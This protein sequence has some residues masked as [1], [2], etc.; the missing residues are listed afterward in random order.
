MARITVEDCL[1]KI[2]NMF[3]L[4]LV[5][6]KRA[7][8]LAN[9]AHP[10]VDWENDKPT[11]VALREIA[12]GYIT[13]EI[14]TQRDKP[15]EDILAADLAAVTPMSADDLLGS[16]PVSIGDCR[17]EPD[18]GPAT[19]PV[20]QPPWTM[21]PPRSIESSSSVWRTD[22]FGRLMGQLERYL[23]SRRSAEHQRGLRV[24]RQGSPR[25]AAAQRRSVHL[26][27]RRR[28]GNPRQPPSRRRVDQGG[29]AAR[30][31]RGHGKHAAGDPRALRR[32]RRVA[33]R[34]RQQDRSPALRQRGR[35]SGRELPQDAARDGEGPARH[36]RQ[37]RRSHAQHAHD[38]VV[39]RREAAAHRAR[40]ARHLRADRESA[41]RLFDQA[42]ARR[43]GLQDRS[44]RIATRCSSARCGAPRATSVSCCARSSRS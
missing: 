31:R 30:R 21:V 44:I 16:R 3:Q 6:A 43:L 17:R 7:R 28:R 25:P 40:D 2:P 11:V 1:E 39:G 15:V 42:R 12:E 35:G 22:D 9:G 18:R 5:A 41:R 24:Q 29:V 34:R 37:A 13:E 38:P 33:R 20:S 26:A 4:V 23:P 8:Q 14:L 32:R 27:P 36:P 10:M 19:T